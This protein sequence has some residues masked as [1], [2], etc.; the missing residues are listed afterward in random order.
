MS[1]GRWS[2]DK[3]SHMFSMN[4]FSS[5]FTIDKWR[6]RKSRWRRR[7]L[8]HLE[9]H[10]RIS[11][12][13]NLCQRDI[14]KTTSLMKNLLPRVGVSLSSN[15]KVAQD[16]RQ[17]SKSLKSITKAFSYNFKYNFAAVSLLLSPND[18]SPAI[19]NICF[20]VSKWK[21]IFYDSFCFQELMLCDCESEQE[22]KVNESYK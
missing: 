2:E 8:F 20:A 9:K 15:L 12:Q 19:I 21:W 6:N 3:L 17:T 22:K 4:Q 16:W 18:V 1:F 5:F 13:F 7:N 10:E 14:F 11:K